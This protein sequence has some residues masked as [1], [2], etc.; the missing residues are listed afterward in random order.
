[1]SAPPNAHHISTPRQ[2]RLQIPGQPEPHRTARA[3]SSDP[4]VS[5]YR[6]ERSPT[7]LGPFETVATISGRHDTNWADQ[8]LGDRFSASSSSSG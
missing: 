7:S 2:V 1:M 5:G 8:P 3:A 6:V 4:T